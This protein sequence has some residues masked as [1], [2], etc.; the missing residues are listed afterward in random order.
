MKQKLNNKKI[1]TIKASKPGSLSCHLKLVKHEHTGKIIHHHYTSHLALVI[2]LLIVGL[3]LFVNGC[4]VNAE[5]LNRSQSVLI[6]AVV[7][8]TSSNVGQAT[9]PTNITNENLINWFNTPVPFYLLAVAITLG[10]WGGDLFDR[11]FGSGKNCRKRK[12][13]QS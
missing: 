3:F 5:S 4:M 6:N 1:A 9:T 2:I 12:F 7:P 13:K 8:A 11:K 10:F